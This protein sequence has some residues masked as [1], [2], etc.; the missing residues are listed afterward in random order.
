[1]TNTK[2]VMTNMARVTWTTLAA[3]SICMLGNIAQASDSNDFA[4][5][6][7]VEYGDLNLTDTNGVQV[8]YSRIS[9]AARTVC[10]MPDQRELARAAIAKRCVEQAMVQAITTM[11]NPL[12]TNL[13]LSK[14]GTTERRF[15]T[16]ARIG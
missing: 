15:A 12:L 14:T 6:K 3:A 2:T 1:L 9:S 4:A 13:Y 16:V 11:N 5:Q 8:L 7:T 10:E